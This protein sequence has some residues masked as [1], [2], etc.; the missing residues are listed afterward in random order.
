MGLP[1]DP[2]QSSCHMR[3]TAKIFLITLLM[4]MQ[5]YGFAVAE[6][7]FVF[8]RRAPFGVGIDQMGDFRLEFVR[9]HTGQGRH[10]VHG[11]Y[12]IPLHQITDQ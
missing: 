12:L 6:E 7:V 10:V 5:I 9:S 1:A 2:Q 4:A 8:L 11:E 3:F